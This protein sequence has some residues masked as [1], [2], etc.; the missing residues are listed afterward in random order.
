VDEDHRDGRGSERHRIDRART[1]AGHFGPARTLDRGLSDLNPSLLATDPAGDAVLAW[2]KTRLSDEEQQTFEVP[3]AGRI[4][5]RR[6]G[7]TFGPAKSFPGIPTSV[8]MDGSGNAIAVGYV[9]GSQRLVVETKRAGAS[10]FAHAQ[11]FD[12]IPSVSQSEPLGIEP[13][14]Q[15]LQVVP[16][17]RGALL[18][19]VGCHDDVSD[20]T[21]DH[22]QL[23]VAVAGPSLV[24][25]RPQRLPGSRAPSGE[26]A[27]FGFAVAARPSGGAVLV[28]DT[29]ERHPRVMRGLL[30]VGARRVADVRAISSPGVTAF[31]PDVA[32]DARGAGLA[33]WEEARAG[34]SRIVGA[35]VARNGRV[36]A[37]RRLS[38]SGATLPGVFVNGAGATFVEWS[39]RAGTAVI[40][41]LP[42]AR[43]GSASVLGGIDDSQASLVGVDRAGEALAT[44]FVVDDGIRAALWRA[45][46][47][48][49]TTLLAPSGDANNPDLDD[50]ELTPSGRAFVIGHRVTHEHANNVLEVAT[51]EPGR[52]FAPKLDLGDEG[53]FPSPVL[54]MNASDSALLLTYDDANHVL[55]FT[56]R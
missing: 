37:R 32:L 14:A 54:A 20:S 56:G 51:R 22:P 53:N 26:S 18:A 4:A 27:V 29:Y 6:A 50:A 25:G 17:R 23:E 30:R 3:V 31:A 48:P 10:R 28:W 21:C 9:R 24:F 5:V 46:A 35:T 7:H 49:S 15:P 39:T 16:L 40:S 42:G 52:P 41:H 55:A 47:K 33:V 2:E 13:G 44:W 1:Q 34:G 12:G 38:A 11:T 19:W 36:G 45:D 43:F 8:T